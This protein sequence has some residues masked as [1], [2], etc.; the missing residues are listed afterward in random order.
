MDSTLETVGRDLDEA[1][2]KLQAV[3][4]TLQAAPQGAPEICQAGRQAR[5]T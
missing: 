4:Q 1:R 2:A 5:A 3:R